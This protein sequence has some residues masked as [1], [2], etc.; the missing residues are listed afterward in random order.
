MNFY[1]ALAT[2]VLGLHALVVLFNV[3]GVFLVLRFPWLRM[4]HAGSLGLTWLFYVLPTL[5][6]LTYLEY[7]LK[8]LADPSGGPP[9]G[10]LARAFE[11]LVY[12][13]VPNW[14]VF[15]LFTL[16]CGFCGYLYFFSGRF[17][18]RGQS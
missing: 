8:D 5:C 3:F 13:D 6:P 14:L 17:S 12:W 18:K 10:F 11:Y 7:W 4:W 16:L 9:R 1:G 2:A 15:A